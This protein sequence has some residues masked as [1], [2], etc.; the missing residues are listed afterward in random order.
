M[1]SPLCFLHV[2]LPNP[3]ALCAFENIGVGSSTMLSTS[4]T[5]SLVEEVIGAAANGFEP[6]AFRV[7]S[8]T[9]LT[10]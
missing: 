4:S 1:E 10:M 5:T 7:A 9:I 6:R 3:S 8:A 2:D